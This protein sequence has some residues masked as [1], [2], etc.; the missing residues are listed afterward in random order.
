MEIRPCRTICTDFARFAFRRRRLVLA[1][2]AACGRSPPSPSLRAAAGRP[3]TPSPSRGTEAQNAAAVLQ[4]KLPAFSGGR[5][6]SS[7]PPPTAPPRS[8]IRPTGP[9]S[10]DGRR[11]SS[12][13]FRRSPWSRVPSRAAWYP[14][15]ARSR[16]GQVQWSAQ[17]ASVK[18]ASLNAVKAAM[19]PLQADGVQVAYN[20]SVY[21][22]W[23]TAGFRDAR[24]DRP[25]HRLRDPDGHLRRAFAAAGMPILGAII[26]RDHHLD[27]HHRR[28]VGGDLSP[29]P[30]P[31]SR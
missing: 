10:R 31:R 24:A 29:R 18:D 3:T 4:A 21:P 14:R 27:G 20:G 17:A 25:D 19:K 15:A 30:R 26:G 23:R 11:P 7:S 28:R 8:P 16:L 22:G 6:R 9:R 1:V 13:R 12:S 5:T 2:W